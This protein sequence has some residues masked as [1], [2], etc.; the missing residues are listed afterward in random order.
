MIWGFGRPLEEGETFSRYFGF[1]VGMVEELGLLGL[2]I[3]IW[4][5]YFLS[6]SSQQRLCRSLAFAFSSSKGVMG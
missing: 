2:L 5:L 4:H 1:K 3:D 6:Y